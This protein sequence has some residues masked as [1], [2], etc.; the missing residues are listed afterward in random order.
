MKNIEVYR[1]ID[2]RKN[3]AFLFCTGRDAYLNVKYFDI[4]AVSSNWVSA[5]DPIE[6]IANQCKAVN[7]ATSTGISEI[8]RFSYKKLPKLV[9]DLFEEYKS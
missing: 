9:K 2:Y 7:I 6:F 1:Y 4:Y 8:K 5:S 3:V